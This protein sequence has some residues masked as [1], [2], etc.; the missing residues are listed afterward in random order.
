MRVTTAT[1]ETYDLDA[2]TGWE[3]KKL[4]RELRAE[5]AMYSGNV[6]K[7]EAILDQWAIVDKVIRQ[8]CY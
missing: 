1:N 4:G 6:A 2:M 8:K 3:V 7:R 5:A